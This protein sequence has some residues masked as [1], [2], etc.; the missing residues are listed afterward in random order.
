MEGLGFPKAFFVM[1]TEINW[2]FGG[3]RGQHT[4]QDRGNL[5]LFIGTPERE[6]R[7]TSGWEHAP[8]HFTFFAD[9]NQ[10]EGMKKSIKS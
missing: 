9:T 3:L 6:K 7:S 1:P 5:I 10:V 8:G 4:T 2:R